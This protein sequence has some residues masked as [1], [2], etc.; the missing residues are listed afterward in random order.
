MPFGECQIPSHWLIAQVDPTDEDAIRDPLVAKMLSHLQDGDQLW[1]Y[2][3][4]ARP[5][6][7]GGELGL[8]LIRKG[9]PVRVL[10]RNVK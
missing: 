1:H 9:K 7:K 8:V 3:E 5:G 4:S 10:I 2:D 6:S